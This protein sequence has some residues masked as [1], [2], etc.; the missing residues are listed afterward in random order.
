MSRRLMNATPP[1]LVLLVCALNAPPVAGQ[2][3]IEL[4][5]KDRLIEADFEELYRVGSLQGGD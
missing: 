4:P 3:V 5:A 2:E 1:G